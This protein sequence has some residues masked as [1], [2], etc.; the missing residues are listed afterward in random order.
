[1]PDMHTLVF[2]DLSLICVPKFMIPAATTL[3]V[4]V[5]PLISLV[6]TCNIIVSDFLGI[7]G[8]K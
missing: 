8:F 4:F 6:P 2:G 7:K 5:L 1:M 3:V